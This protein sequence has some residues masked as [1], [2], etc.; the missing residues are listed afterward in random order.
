MKKCT[1]GLCLVL[2]LLSA[3]ALAPAEEM[4]VA[5][6]SITYSVQWTYYDGHVVAIGILQTANDPD[7]ALVEADAYAPGGPQTEPMRAAAALS[8]TVIG[9]YCG[10]SFR[11]EGGDTLPLGQGGG[12]LSAGKSIDSYD[13]LSL[14]AGVSPDSVEVD[15]ILGA[16][17][18]AAA[19][20]DE[21]GGFSFPILK[22]GEPLLHV[23]T[24]LSLGSVT[25]RR[26]VISRTPSLLII[27]LFHDPVAAGEFPRIALLSAEDTGLEHRT[28]HGGMDS[29]GLY[30][31]EE[32][33]SL[34]AD[35][36]LPDVLT[37]RYEGLDLALSIDLPSGT[38][39]RAE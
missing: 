8:D 21:E 35:A 26:V 18:S 22:T 20:Y 13:W 2:T 12:G 38:V 16:R 27:N 29:G 11:Y 17:T 4:I 7:A 15:A 1:A 24:D 6:D 39:D 28:S 14:A 32:V 33:Y 9:A 34:A 36:P 30:H 23:E 31:V 25:L 3:A 19:R 5:L 10:V 37:L